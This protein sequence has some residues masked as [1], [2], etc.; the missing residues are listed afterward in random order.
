MLKKK[1]WIAA[2]LCLSLVFGG[3]AAGGNEDKEE[4]TSEQTEE[5]EVPK[6]PAYQAKLDVIEPAAYGN[7]EG[8]KL[9]KGSYISIIGKGEEG[10]YWKQVKKGVD[11]AAKDL[12]VQL[13]YEGKDKIK[14]V[15]SAPAET[16]NV[17]E[18][19][20]LLD[21]ELSRYPVAL[22]IAIVDENACDVQFDLA[23]DSE[24]PIVAF[25]SG[26]DYQGLMATVSTNNTESAQVVAD[27]LGK[28]LEGTGEI[29]IVANDS[30]SK[31][32]KERVSAFTAKL[33]ESYPEMKVVDTVHLDALEDWQEKIAAEINA[34]TYALSGE[35]TGTALPEDH[36]VEPDS[37]TEE[38]VLDYVFKKHPDLKGVYGTNQNAVKAAANAIERGERDGLTVVGYD[39]DEEQ[40][41]M[42]EDGEVD[43]LLVQNPFGMGYA[44]VIAAARAAIG[45]GNE[46]YVDTGYMWVT[47]ENMK[48]EEVKQM[49]SE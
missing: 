17:D 46:A 8:L 49:L 30:K 29:V 37:I 18:Q 47:K 19:V 43:G 41:Q 3:C 6:K 14:V 15:Y 26:S 32:N 21:E 5:Q 45:A 12:N 22:G 13:G 44:S 23:A 38:Q 2:A 36:Q 9:E 4:K 25:D 16:D 10:Q 28:K 35:P 42:L 40:L 24:I 39:A 7:A 11:Q 27:N 48:S 20:N 31:N 1:Q 33:K 34:G